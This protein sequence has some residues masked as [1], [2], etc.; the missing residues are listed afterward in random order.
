[1]YYVYVL[2]NDFV[3]KFYIGQTGNL[4]QRIQS[5]NWKRGNHFTAK[6][7]GEWKLIYEESFSTRS[8]AI[9]REKQLKTSR[10]RAYISSYIPG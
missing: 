7:E 5:H 10:G 4:E 3:E 1:M 6:F 2:Y 9:R 8:E